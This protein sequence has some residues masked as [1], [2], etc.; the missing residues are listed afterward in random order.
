M[1]GCGSDVPGHWYSLSRALNP[2]W[3]TY[4]PSQHEMRT[5]CDDVWTKHGLKSHTRFGTEVVR[6]TWDDRTHTYAVM[7]E[8]VAS[9]T[10]RT[11]TA[12]VVINAT[13]GFMSPRV[14]EDLGRGRE[15]FGGV[16]WHSAE[17][18]HDVTLEGKRVGVIGNGCS[19][20]V[21]SSVLVGEGGDFNSDFANAISAQFVPQISK[22]SSVE[23]INFCRSPQWYIPRVSFIRLASFF[24]RCTRLTDLLL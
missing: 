8:D 21:H 18:R 11:V 10:H 19:A 2:H 7:L 14:P 24:R 12:R 22:D 20:Y 5:Y 13:G 23:V 9:R 6:A 16:A 3:K 17:W 1:Q 15:R 4:Y